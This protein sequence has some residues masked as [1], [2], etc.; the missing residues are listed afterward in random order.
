VLIEHGFMSNPTE[1][2]WLKGHVEQ[3]AQAEHAALQRFFGLGP[4]PGHGSGQHG[5]PHSIA[6]TSDAALLAPAR[7]PATRAE[8]YLVARSHGEYTDLDVT[9][10]V[11]DYYATAPPAGLD[12]LLA[13]AQMVEETGHLTSFW[14]QRPRRNPAGIGVTGKPGEGISFPDWKTAVRAHV[15][16]LLAYALPKGRETAAQA[17]LIEEALSFRAL[18]DELRGVA[19]TL[20]GLIGRWAADP[21]YAVN[22]SRLANE[23]LAAGG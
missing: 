4:V 17:G 12:P 3:L 13:I 6:V 22:I 20:R 1:R 18:P 16:R 2:A 19:P 5:D 11:E 14:S 10:I 23:I 21:Q 9:H 7:A 8:A 15:G